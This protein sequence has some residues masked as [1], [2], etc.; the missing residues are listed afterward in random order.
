MLKLYNS[1]NKEKEVFEPITPGKVSMYN[2]GPTV[3]DFAHVGNLRSYI[4]ADIFRRV[5]EYNGYEVKQVINITDVGHLT[6]DTDEGEDKMEKRAKEN[7]K[8]AKEIA[9]FFTEAFFEDIR[10]LNIKTKDTLFPRATEYIKEQIEL[11][12]KL[13][14]K[15][16]TY[17][18]SDGIY[19]N[20]SK[21]SKYDV[22]NVAGGNIMQ[23]ARVEV[24]S[25]KMHPTDFALWKFSPI[26]EK[27]QQEWESPWGVGFPGWH[28]ECSAMSIKLLGEQFDVHT[29]GIDHKFPHHPNEI[30][31][32]ESATGKSPFARYWLHSEF[33][34]FEGAKM[35]KSVGN[36]LTLSDIVS[37]GFI[38]I[39]Y[40]YWILGAHY[41]KTI[42]F[43]WEAIRGASNA[44]NKLL[45]HSRDL[46]M[47]EPTAE[48]DK[49]YIQEL[50]EYLNDDFD[51]PNAL[52]LLWK[53]IKDKNLESDVKY[54]T[55]REIDLVLGLGLVSG[56]S[57]ESNFE[58]P[59][60]VKELM[61]K[62]EKARKRKNWKESDRLRDE[63]ESYGFTV[64]DTPQGAR[65]KY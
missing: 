27:R 49:E 60:E 18:T 64:K 56:I 53:L 4:S 42:S 26:Q 12:K 15:G 58:I 31:Q 7:K 17:K 22:F 10:S 8:T 38:P 61:K 59:E 35:A 50:T 20:T 52:A 23:G 1:L 2:C 19:F 9:E 11:I 51:T 13:E 24:N 21:L 28:L 57:E 39:V 32:T 46:Y 40:R 41:R 47:E 6:G 44:Y 29:G 54:A 30:A 48:P 3:Y 55:L 33:L 5:F 43:S 63:I 36:F 45:E 34:S 65:I 25:E 37:K 62:R 14:E 16:Y